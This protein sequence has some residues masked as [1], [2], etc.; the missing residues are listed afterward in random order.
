M[1]IIEKIIIVDGIITD[2]CSRNSGNGNGNGGN[3][4]EGRNY[5]NP[6]NNVMSLNNMYMTMRITIIMIKFD[7]LIYW[8]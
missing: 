7:S 2:F 6:K 8:K 4:N 1:T 5:F 3:C